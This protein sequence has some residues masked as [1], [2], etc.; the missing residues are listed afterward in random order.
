ML[1]CFFQNLN[2]WFIKWLEWHY[3]IQCHNTMIYSLFCKIYLSKCL[4][5]P[6]S[7]VKNPGKGRCGAG[8]WTAARES[9]NKS[10]SKLDEEGVEV[11]VCRHGVLLKAL[12]MFRGEI[13]AYPLYLQKQLASQTVQFFCSD[14]VCKYWPYLQRVVDHCPELGG[15][16]NM[17]P[18]LSIMHAKAHSWMCEVIITIRCISYHLYHTF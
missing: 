17:R 11:A 5:L 9:A 16:L 13:F 14:V 3:C 18:F 7:S 1:A 6:I 8:Q 12:N 10:A 2:I 15:L 4:Y